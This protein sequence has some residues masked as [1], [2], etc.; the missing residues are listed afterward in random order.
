MI[1]VPSIQHRAML[2][3][4]IVLHLVWYAHHRTAKLACQAMYNT[5][6]TFAVRQRYRLGVPMQ[7]PLATTAFGR[8]DELGT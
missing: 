5:A 7:F 6:Y 3:A 2:A 4:S 1:C 8:R